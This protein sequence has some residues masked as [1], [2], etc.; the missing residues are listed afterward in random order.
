MVTNL[1]KL[2][3]IKITMRRLRIIFSFVLVALTTLLISCSS[4]TQAKIPL[5][6]TPEKIA[7]LQVFAEPVETAKEQMTILRGFIED[8][9]WTDT[10]TFMHGPL[11]S[12]RQDVR[13]LSKKFLPKEQTEAAEIAQNLFS[14]FDR[15][16]IAAKERNY[17][18][19]EAQYVEA[20][21]DLETFLNLIPQTKNN[22]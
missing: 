14:H 19:A 17:S 11:G 22:S 7:Q 21:D 5:V 6:Y 10:R 13:I 3:Q 2:N 20:L 1:V 9:N 8:E 16:D 18:L 15:I 12:L 4:G